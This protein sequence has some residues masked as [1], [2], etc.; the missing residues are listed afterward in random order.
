[1]KKIMIA[2]I[3]LSLL[4]GTVVFAQ[5]TASTTDSSSKHKSKKSKHSKTT[6]DTTATK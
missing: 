2:A 6:S 1:M 5:N 3:G 4:S